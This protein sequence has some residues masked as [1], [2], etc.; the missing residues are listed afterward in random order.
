MRDNKFASTTYHDAPFSEQ[1][2]IVY[3]QAGVDQLM[4]AKSEAAKSIQHMLGKPI[5]EGT[6]VEALRFVDETPEDG[7][8]LYRHRATAA[9]ELMPQAYYHNHG[10]SFAGEIVVAGTYTDCFAA[11]AAEVPEEP[12][13]EEPVT[14]EPVAE[15][16]VAEEPVEPAIEG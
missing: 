8:C 4:V 11:Y 16:P 7:F 14:E 5:L 13:T 9:L 12:V 2:Y 1:P 3:A 6:A 15:E 10:L